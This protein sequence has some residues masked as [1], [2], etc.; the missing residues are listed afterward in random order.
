[1]TGFTAT[2][3]EAC[4]CIESGALVATPSIPAPPPCTSSCPDGT[5]PGGFVTVQTSASYAPLLNYP[6]IPNPISITGTATV[7]ID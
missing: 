3:S 4:Y 7:R 6:S 2:P 1:V 5:T